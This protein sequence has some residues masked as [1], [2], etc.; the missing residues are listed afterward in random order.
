MNSDRLERVMARMKENGLMQMAVSDPM[1]IY[2]LTGQRIY[3]GER[4][5]ALLLRRGEKPVLF[6]NELF[7]AKNGPWETVYYNDSDDA[8]SL[9]VPFIN[10]N[11]QLGI[12]KDMPSRFLIS[13][14]E[15]NAASGYV[16]ASAN[17]DLVRAVKAPD[18]QEA[19]IKSSEINDRAMGRFTLLVKEGLTESQIA[20]L[21]PDI[22]KEEGAQ[23]V[24][25]SPIVSFGMNAADPHHGPGSSVLTKG[26]C[27]LFDVGGKYDGYCSDMT[28]TFFTAPPTDKQKE[29]YNTVLEANLA[30]EDMI[31]PGVRLSDID[32]TARDIITKAG[33]G[34]YF[35][36]RLG[37]F[38]GLTEHEYGDVS[39][40]SEWI[41]EPGMTFS[42]EPGIY[43]PGDYGVRIEDLVLVTETGCKVLNAYPKELTVLAI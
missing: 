6:L 23:G 19:M 39:S 16:N 4:M 24:S 35:T 2:Y 43:L 5:L 11:E 1:S 22:Y 3:P 7:T 37:H 8:V 13:L 12:D 34:K 21:I 28:R 32:K 40:S 30:A 33:Y 15:K 14:M 27:V 41:A 17:V 42:C 36:H 31:R 18:E 20:S 38:I 10:E 9:M 29:V 26:Q 25:F